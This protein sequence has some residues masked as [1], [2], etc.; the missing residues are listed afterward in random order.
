MLMMAT[1]LSAHFTLEEL[2]ASDTARQHGIA[3]TP[4]AE[5]LPNLQRLASVLERVRSALG[6]RPLLVSSG[7]RCE[8]L[9]RRVGGAASSAHLRGLAADVTQT[10]VTPRQLAQS[11]ALLVPELGI[12]QLIVECD[13]WVHIGLC[14]GRPRQQL[15]T[16]RAG[17]GYAMGIA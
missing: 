7:Y 8:A 5:L 12:D 10:G 13:R 1:K 6:D 16:Y 15:L 9:N 4:P 14:D 2:C 17:T 11:I 3:N